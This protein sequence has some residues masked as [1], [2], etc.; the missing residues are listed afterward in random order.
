[1]KLLTFFRLALS[2]DGIP[3]SKRV[4][5]FILLLTFIFIVLYNIFTGKKPDDTLQSQLYYML[6]T[7]VGL[8][9][10]SNI[11]NAIKDVKIKQSNNNVVVGA[12]S[13]VQPPITPIVNAPEPNVVIKN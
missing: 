2:E 13:P 12:P 7:V 3:S 11:V 8:V 1:M 9:F 4:V 10:G 6:T 5:L